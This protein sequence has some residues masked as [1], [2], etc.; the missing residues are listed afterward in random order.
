MRSNLD[1]GSPNFTLRLGFLPGEPIQKLLNKVTLKWQ[2][3]GEKSL[4]IELN[5]F[6][7]SILQRE[8][9]ITSEL[10]NCRKS[11]NF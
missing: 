4:H 5:I 2:N 11:S 7:R 3:S 10:S 6:F 8:I 9:K 1:F